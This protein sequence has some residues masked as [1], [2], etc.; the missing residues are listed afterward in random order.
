M[1]KNASKY[2]FILLFSV[3]TTLSYGQN[4]ISIDSLNANIN[5]AFENIEELDSIFFEPQIKQEFISDYLKFYANYPTKKL[6]KEGELITYYSTTKGIKDFILGYNGTINNINDEVSS[7]V[8][9]TDMRAY[10][11]SNNSRIMMM[12]MSNPLKKYALLLPRIKQ[13]NNQT[14]LYL[15]TKF[16]CLVEQAKNGIRVHCN[17]KY[18][19]EF[20]SNNKINCSYTITFAQQEQKIIMCECEE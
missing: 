19:I 2:A 11:K 18:L 10:Y 12:K 13:K 9:N 16:I 1:I 20:K 5:L 14:E 3:L 15:N 7:A 6:D 17:K 8:M 4:S